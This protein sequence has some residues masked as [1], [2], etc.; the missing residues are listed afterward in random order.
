MQ[1]QTTSDLEA[2]KVPTLASV[3]PSSDVTA[4]NKTRGA[5][6][7]RGKS[8]TGA[9]SRKAEVLPGT[10]TSASRSRPSIHEAEIRAKRRISELNERF[11]DPE[12]QIADN[13]EAVFDILSDIYV[14]AYDLAKDEAARDQWL[15]RG[16]LR[17]HGNTENP[18]HA[19]VKCF[20]SKSIHS[21]IRH[22]VCRWAKAIAHCCDERI[23]PREFKEYLRTTTIKNAIAAYKRSRRT[24]DP[25]DGAEGQL[26]EQDRLAS[27]IL[28]APE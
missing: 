11:A 6:D 5:P 19:V 2:V 24:Q 1:N 18:H 23:S 25:L 28:S 3:G 22:K 9:R 15:S 4:R 20:F 8:T 16:G 27:R 7:F 13:S 17:V 21:S 14:V 10:T 26:D 12:R